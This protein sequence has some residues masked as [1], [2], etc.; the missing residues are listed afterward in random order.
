MF[1]VDK[2]RAGFY[3]VV[4]FRQP[5]NPLYAVVDAANQISRSGYYATDNP[6]VKV[7]YLKDNVD[8]ADISDAD[9][10]VILKQMQEESISNVCGL[11]FNNSD[12][13]DRQVLY[14]Y[15]QN[16]VNTETLQ[17]GLITHKISVSI[18]KNIAFEI[19]R[20][21]LDFDGAGDIDLMLFNTADVNPLFTK[22]I[23]ISSTH[24]EEVLNW[25]VDNSGNTYKGEYYLGYRSNGAAIG[26]LKPFKRDYDQS[27]ITS[28]IT[29]LE[30]EKIQF[31]GHATNTLPDL[32]TEESYDEA[33]GL[34][35]DITVY[36][37]YTD[38]ILQNEILFARAIN[39]DLQIN[40]LGHFLS[41]LRSNKNERHSD[42]N[43]MRVLQEIE[44][45][46]GEGLVK[47]TGLRPQLTR[48]ISQISNE[49]DRIKKGYF[50][51][52]AKV[53]TM[54]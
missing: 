36:E 39:T 45:Q 46:T 53:Q 14:P 32:T 48:S 27:E 22:T 11:V 20:I 33:S 19:T 4:G 15:A 1:N 13:I 16:K 17:L 29:Y 23:T 50:G 54:Q 47:I 10:N 28:D 37:D 21:L 6:F 40:A 12:Y 9:F 24:Q 5:Y 30:T 41:S 42:R 2:I 51:D 52:F 34:N 26:T 44:G 38:L 31:V 18:K 35:P 7:E 43:S 25:K 8:Y 3:G 49:I